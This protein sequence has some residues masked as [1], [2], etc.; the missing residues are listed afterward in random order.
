MVTFIWGATFVIIQHALEEISVTWFIFY[1]FFLASLVSL[2]ILVIFFYRTKD[3]ESTKINFFNTRGWF[4]GILLFGSYLFQT[5]G[6]NY[7]TPSNAAFITSLSVILVPVVLVLKGKKLSKTNTASFLLATFGLIFITIGINL[8]KLKFNFGDIIILG[9]AICL[10]FQIIYTDQFVKIYDPLE[11]TI[12]QL[13]STTVLSFLFAVVFEPQS[14]H[15]IIYYSS[16]V[17]GAILFTAL[18][19]TIYGFFVQTYAQK[20]VNPILIAIIFTFEPIFALLFSLWSGVE[21]LTLIRALGMLLILSG[22]FIAIYKEYTSNENNIE[23]IP[24]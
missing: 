19:A 5:I 24:L 8:S 22:T 18:L 7:T 6:L 13:F 12:T 17:L 20:T 16:T 14:F 4:L 10:A 15:L 2:V 11:L 3:P 9:T 23:K 1:R 21:Q